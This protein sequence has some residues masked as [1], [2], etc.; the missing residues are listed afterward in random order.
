[1]KSHSWREWEREEEEV[2]DGREGNGGGRSRGRKCSS[3]WSIHHAMFDFSM[4][5]QQ[6]L[7]KQK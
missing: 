1:M 5:V 3:S 2:G 4:G 7:S 6:L